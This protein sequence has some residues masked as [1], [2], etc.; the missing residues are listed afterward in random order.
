MANAARDAWEEAVRD[1][2]V[3]SQQFPGLGSG[4]EKQETTSS[5]KSSAKDEIAGNR[6]AQSEKYAKRLVFLSFFI[7]IYEFCMNTEFEWFQRK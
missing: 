4:D 7:V 5:E 2:G 6:A 1:R 3:L